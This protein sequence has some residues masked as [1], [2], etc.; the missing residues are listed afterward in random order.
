LWIATLILL[1]FLALSLGLVILKFIAVEK[2]PPE[3]KIY[4]SYCRRWARRGHP[5][6]LSE[7]PTAYAQRLGL[8]HPAEAQ[9]AV[10]IAEFYLRLRYGKDK[11]SAVEI[12]QFHLL[13]RSAIKGKYFFGQIA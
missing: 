6:K 3:V 10:K 5:R 4:S 1:P 9:K 11:F 7:T 8:T 2:V 13:C 12:K